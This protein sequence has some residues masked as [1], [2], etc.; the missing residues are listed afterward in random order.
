MTGMIER[1]AAGTATAIMGTPESARNK[2][3]Y[4]ES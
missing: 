4:M 1:S 2:G 3:K